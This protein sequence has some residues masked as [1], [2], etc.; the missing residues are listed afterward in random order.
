[1]R[2]RGTSKIKKTISKGK[3]TKDEGLAKVQKKRW[4]DRSCK[5]TQSIT[6]RWNLG[7]IQQCQTA[8]RQS[9]PETGRTER[10]THWMHHTLR[11]VS[12]TGIRDRDDWDFSNGSYQLERTQ[13]EM[14]VIQPVPNF[15]PQVSCP[16]VSAVTRDLVARVECGIKMGAPQTATV[17]EVALTETLTATRAGQFN[18]GIMPSGAVHL[19]VTLWYV[20]LRKPT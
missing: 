16:P 2:A 6:P 12:S 7:R 20:S 14:K 3:S 15:T 18:I 19:K 4:H 9:D 1:M 8:A 10:T 11:W 13:Q 17:T 5:T